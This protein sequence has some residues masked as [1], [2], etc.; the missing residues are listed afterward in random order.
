MFKM[1]YKVCYGWR[2]VPV[3]SVDMQF[4]L[5]YRVFAAFSPLT[6]TSGIRR[7]FNA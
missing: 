2:T 1:F 6:G 5:N 4:T 3:F 7:V